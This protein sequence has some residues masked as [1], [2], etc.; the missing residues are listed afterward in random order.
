MPIS[1]T[2]LSLAKRSRI[3][4]CFIEDVPAITT[5]KLTLVNIKTVNTWFTEL[6]RRL[7]VFSTLPPVDSESRFLAYHKRRIT[8]FNGTA[9]A[10]TPPFLLESRL[11]YQLKARF[12]AAV[13]EIADDLLS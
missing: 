2:R 6:R 7:V 12:R 5:A 10:S 4:Q 8:K 13:I 11:R 1:Y 3:V 9:R